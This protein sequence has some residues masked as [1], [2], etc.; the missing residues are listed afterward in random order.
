MLSCENYSFRG[1]RA[2]RL[3]NDLIEVLLLLGGGHVARMSFLDLNLNPLWE[4][5]WATMEPE[6]YDP[7]RNPE[8][9]PSEGR[10]L[11]S[12]AGHSLC[13]DHFGD[14]SPAEVAAGGYFHGEAPNLSWKVI[15][16]D[17][18][19]NSTS[20]TYGLE[21]PEAGIRFS[22]KVTLRPA[23]SIVWF[24]EEI[25]NLRRRDMPIEYQQHVTLGPPFLEGGVTRV[26]IPGAKGRTFLRSLGPA[27]RLKP[28]QDFDWPIAPGRDSEVSV[29]I[30]PECDQSYSLCTVVQKKYE[31]E[32]FISAW[33]PRLGL[34]LGYVFPLDR[35]P[36]TA[37][38][39]ENGGTTD[40]PYNGRTRAWGIEFGTTPL[41]VTRMENLTSGMLFDKQRY[42]L[43]PARGSLRT[44]YRAFLLKIPEDWRRVDKMVE[45]GTKLYVCDSLYGRQLA[46]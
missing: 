26:G 46:V 45:S 30:F 36:W 31:G 17:V 3:A 27:D 5:P 19:L 28:D 43:L 44:Q 25:E 18:Q 13:L 35:F 29:D 11:A 15:G 23:S 2:I 6:E 16:R 37:L 14:L 22:R 40:S 38:W 21:L 20:L 1:R 4:P 10:L 41:P 12:L 24:E 32:S 7:K 9:G 39:E 42:R 33:N 8:Y 34:M